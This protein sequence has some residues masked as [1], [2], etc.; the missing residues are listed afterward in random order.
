MLPAGNVMVRSAGAVTTGALASPIC[1]VTV[2]RFEVSIPS[3]ASYVK[4]SAPQT[5]VAGMNVHCG[6][7]VVADRLQLTVPPPLL[8]ASKLLTVKTSPSS[9]SVSLNSTSISTAVF[10]AVDAESSTATGGTLDAPT[11]SKL[12]VT[13][14]SP[15]PPLPGSSSQSGPKVVVS[16]IWS[17]SNTFPYQEA[18]HVYVPD[19]AGAGKVSTTGPGNTYVSPSTPPT[20]TGQLAQV[21]L[22]TA[23]AS[24]DR[25]PTLLQSLSQSLAR[26]QP[27][28]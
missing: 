8:A 12:K 4:L 6:V 20:P 7:G 25:Q 27:G 2:A 23:T 3:V 18:D 11:T 28:R 14:S 24:S 19:V 26:T 15:C 1:I 5:F 17:K 22:A 9:A 10:T 16:P 21:L 13:I